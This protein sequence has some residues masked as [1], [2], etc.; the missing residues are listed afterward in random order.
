MHNSEISKQ[1]GTEWKLLSESEKRPFIDEAK[2]LRVQHMRDH[3]NYK[4]RPRRRTRRVSSSDTRRPGSPRGGA[5]FTYPSFSYM[6]PMDAF[7][8][9]LYAAAAPGLLMPPVSPHPPLMDMAGAHN[10][11]LRPVTLGLAPPP[12][13][14]PAA[15][16]TA[17][18]QIQGE[19]SSGSGLSHGDK[20]ID[21]NTSSVEG[22]KTVSQQNLVT[23]DTMT[24][25]SLFSSAM[26]T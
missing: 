24:L 21:T 17:P 19:A 18:D 11:I 13:L 4:Y 14:S 26:F 12:E 1:L 8:R 10:E 6:Y 15:C 9:S 23:Q 2:R 16:S 3:P 20:R 25:T 22:H 7:S 5:L